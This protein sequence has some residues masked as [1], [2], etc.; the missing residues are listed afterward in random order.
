LLT[1]MR[2]GVMM[3][4]S[5]LLIEGLR[6]RWRGRGVV[7]GLRKGG[8]EGGRFGYCFQIIKRV[9]ERFKWMLVTFG[10]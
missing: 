10:A 4:V 1:L 7:E 5:L 3:G 8:E 6:R 9:L 2:V